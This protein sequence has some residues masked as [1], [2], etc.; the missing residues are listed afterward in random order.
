M[1]QKDIVDGHSIQLSLL[2]RDYRRYVDEDNI[3]L[4]GDAVEELSYF[5]EQHINLHEGN[6]TNEE[7]DDM[8]RTDLVPKNS[9]FD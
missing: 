2:I 4:D 5:I 7:Y 3:P 9:V 1:T 8:T 6:I